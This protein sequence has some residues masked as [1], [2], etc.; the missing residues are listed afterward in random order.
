M[1][2]ECNKYNYWIFTSQETHYVSAT[3]TNQLVAVHCEDRTE[4][5]NTFYGQYAEF[6]YVNAGGLFS[7]H[8]ALKSWEKSGLFT[9]YSYLYFTILFSWSAF[10]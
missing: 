5:R 9:N 6:Y 10:R 3:K 1:S 8:W 2:A 7:D 4:H